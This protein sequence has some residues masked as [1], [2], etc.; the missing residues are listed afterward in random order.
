M[1]QNPLTIFL[2]ED[3]AQLV[4]IMFVSI[5]L[6][7]ILSLIYNKYLLLALTMTITMSFQSLLFP[8]EKWLLWGQQ[9]IVYLL[10][11]YCPR[12]YVGHIVTF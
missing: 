5:P 9:Q 12:S 11:L 4:L 10:I 7:Y 8:E 3:Q 2:P 1:L 6:S